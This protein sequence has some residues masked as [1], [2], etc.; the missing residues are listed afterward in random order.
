MNLLKLALTTHLAIVS[1]DYLENDGDI[2]FVLG[3]SLEN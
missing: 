2:I 3:A 1:L